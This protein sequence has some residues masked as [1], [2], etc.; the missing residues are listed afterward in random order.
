MNRD[1]DMG[2]KIHDML[3]EVREEWQERFKEVGYENLETDTELKYLQGKM[4]ALESVST[5]YSDGMC[6]LMNAISDVIYHARNY[7]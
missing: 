5:I 7:K 4:D 2:Q 3:V 1:V 6:H